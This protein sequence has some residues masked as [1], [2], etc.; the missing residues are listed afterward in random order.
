MKNIGEVAFY[1]QE[2]NRLLKK[3]IKNRYND[4]VKQLNI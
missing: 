1:P 2:I 3:S 4:K